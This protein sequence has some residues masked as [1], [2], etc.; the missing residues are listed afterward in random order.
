MSH[1]NLAIIKEGLGHPGAQIELLFRRAL[2]LDD[3]YVF[4]RVGLATI[5]TRRG[6]IGCCR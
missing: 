1:A 4:A 5:L 6:W 2:E 3:V